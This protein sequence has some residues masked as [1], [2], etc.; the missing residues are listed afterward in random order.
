MR[1]I[2]INSVE[3]TLLQLDNI[4]TFE[5]AIKTLKQ[6][7]VTGVIL[8]YRLNHFEDI[9]VFLADG[10]NRNTI[11]LLVATASH[12]DCSSKFKF[13]KMKNLL[14]VFGLSFF[15][16]MSIAQKNNP[17]N[18]RGVDFVTSVNLVS[19]D[20]NAGLVKDFTQESLNKY[21]KMIPLQNQVS[22]DLTSRIVKAVKAPGF[23]FYDFINN[24]TLSSYAKNMYPQLINPKGKSADEFRKTLSEKVGEINLAKID[25][26]EKELLLSVA[27]I[28]FNS[29]NNPVAGRSSCELQSPE[30]TVTLTHTQCIVAFAAA[31]AYIGFQIC[32]VWCGLGGAVVGGLVAA[33]C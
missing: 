2:T 29:S 6:L 14:Y 18:Q 11:F 1:I 32:G 24:S 5:S 7:E 21:S 30:G 10:I 8:D 17:Y 27:A 28:S 9:V 4:F 15:S 26:N 22:L 33:I 19:N 25:R 20:F 3:L 23:N 16:T 13:I 12:L 31:G